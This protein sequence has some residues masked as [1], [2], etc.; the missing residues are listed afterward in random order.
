MSWD[1]VP[2]LGAATALGEILRRAGYNEDA[3]VERLGDDGP[4]ADVEDVP[5]LDRRLAHDELGNLIRLLL[6]YVPVRHDDI[7]GVKELAALNFVAEVDGAVLPQGR[8][9]PTEGVYLAFDG[10]SAGLADPP[11]WVASFTPTSFWLAS[12]TVRPRGGRAVD[13]GTGNGAHA[14]FAARHMDRV[15]ATDI[16]ERALAFTAIGAAL[17]GFTNVETRHGSLF[18]P[19]AG[20]SFDLITCNAP[21]VVSPETKWQYRDGGERGDAFSER[22]VREATGHLNEGGYATLTASW[23]GR[24]EDEPDDHVHAWLDDSG[25]D[26]W[27]CPMRGADPLDHASAWTDHLTADAVGPALDTW[28]SYFEELGAGWVT[29]GV[30]VLHKRAGTRHLVFAEPVDEDDLE[31]AGTQAKRVLANLALLAEGDYRSLRF[32]L[33]KDAWFREEVDFEGDVTDVTLMLDDGTQP[34]LEIEPEEIDILTDAQGIT[35]G[36]AGDELLRA[37]LE[38]GFVKPF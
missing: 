19:V 31:D 14:L 3:I 17:N 10:F 4:A 1:P 35:L 11:G 20:E 9:V 13:V 12:L 24:S 36:S 25:C 21:Y 29:E 32:R 2:D 18:E 6:L 5:V 37:V 33:V 8:I 38:L 15:I 26:A 34:E 28:A 16:N 22:A 7:P 23:L 27:V 30:L